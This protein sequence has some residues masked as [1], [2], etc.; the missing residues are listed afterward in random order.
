MSLSVNVQQAMQVQA[1]PNA[2]VVIAKN[3]KTVLERGD[4][5]AGDSLQSN[6]SCY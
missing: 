3:I 6:Q 4:F 2:K 1:E 5:T